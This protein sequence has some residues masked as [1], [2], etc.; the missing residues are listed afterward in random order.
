MGIKKDCGTLEPHA[1]RGSCRCRTA[2]RRADTADITQGIA[3]SDLP[4][5]LSADLAEKV[6][7][8]TSQVNLKE[9]KLSDNRIQSLWRLR[10]LKKLEYLRADFNDL[11]DLRGLED[12]Q[13]LKRVYVHRNFISS[14]EPLA[15][16][17][18]LEELSIN[19][20]NISSLEPLSSSPKL[21]ILLAHNN[22]I[23]NIKGLENAKDL[24]K[25]FIFK[26]KLTNLD[27][28]E[29]LKSLKVFLFS[30]DS[31]TLPESEKQRVSALFTE[32]RNTKILI[33]G[34]VLGLLILILV[35]MVS[36]KFWEKWRL[37]K[38]KRREFLRLRKLFATQNASF[39]DSKKL[40]RQWWNNLEPQ[41]KRAFNVQLD[42][43]YSLFLPNSSELRELV[44]SN[45]FRI[46]AENLTNL[47][48][49]QNCTKLERLSFYDETPEFLQSFVD[50]TFLGRFRNLKKIEFSTDEIKKVESFANLSKMFKIVIAS[51]DIPYT[52]KGSIVDITQQ[53]SLRYKYPIVAIGN[54]EGLH[55]G[56]S[57][58]LNRLYS[59]ATDTGGEALVLTYRAHTR[60]HFLK[61]DNRPIEPYMILERKHKEHLL[62]H[63]FGVH[64]ILY[65]DFDEVAHF[66]AEEFFKKILLEKLH[67]REIVCGHDTRFGKGKE[68]DYRL[69]MKLGKP[70]G[71]KVRL[72]DP[73][74]M[75]GEI[76]CSKLIR[77][78]IKKGEI[79]GIR[80]YL[81]RNYSVVGTV[82]KGRKIG[83]SLGFPTLNLSPKEEFKIYPAEG[84]YITHTKIGDK[85]YY[86]LTNIG[87]APTVRSDERKKTI[88]NYLYKFNKN[89]YGREVKV[90]FL[91]FLRAEKKFASQAEL[92]AQLK[93]DLEALKQY[94]RVH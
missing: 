93:K 81:S 32:K 74:I 69:L 44:N 4:K 89:I 57:K 84:V 7:G 10:N 28:V 29:K 36:F 75:S 25:I 82:E 17:P 5:G 73:L 85:G 27:G 72:V 35:S 48:G 21:K 14:I 50:L 61:M 34:G 88:E 94:I 51:Q 80:R 38:E 59:R 13:N 16:K 19:H 22:E 9:L 39:F 78:K 52:P 54:F 56:H 8:M 60:E 76:V 40:L 65:L 23:A 58:L 43:G 66:T 53:T 26:N 47:S 55:F 37:R 12:L 64:S 86:G 2:I 18:L 3:I 63:K 6:L 15:N 1:L 87:F 30:E 11:Q 31:K 46:Q 70:Y 24:E 62:F 77:E 71:I 92:M 41:W 20:N 42:N 45:F 90:E 49:L 67:I 68:G 33:I 79:N 91:R 83:G